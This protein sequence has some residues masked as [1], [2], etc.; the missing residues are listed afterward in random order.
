MNNARLSVRRNKSNNQEYKN[1]RWKSKTRKK[2]MGRE[3]EL[4]KSK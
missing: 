1:F 4:T 3:E 2:T